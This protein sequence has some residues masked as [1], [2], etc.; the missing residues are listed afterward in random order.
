MSRRVRFC[1]AFYTSA[2]WCVAK[3]I[4]LIGGPDGMESV[5]RGFMQYQK[6]I[7]REIPETMARYGMARE[8]A[9]MLSN[10]DR[11]VGQLRPN[12]SWTF[13]KDQW[14]A[15]EVV[16]MPRVLDSN[17]GVVTGPPGS[18]ELGLVVTNDHQPPNCDP[19][20]LQS[21]LYGPPGSGQVDAEFVA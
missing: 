16:V 1:I 2:L 6:R 11:L 18:L 21:I 7:I 14:G 10:L 9:E 4:R 20:A 5:L 19:P 3:V 17:T 8:G 12:S 13:H 15:Y